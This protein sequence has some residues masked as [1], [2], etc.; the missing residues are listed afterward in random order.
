MHRER[1]ANLLA[2]HASPGSDDGEGIHPGRS[3]SELAQLTVGCDAD[4]ICVGHTHEPLVCR[5]E[6]V[7]VVNLGS[8]SNPTAPDLRASYVMIDA[9]AS[10]T[11]IEHRRVDYDHAA[12]IEAVRSSRHPEAEFILN[13]QRGK[14]VGRV[15][16]ADQSY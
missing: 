16:H 10:G 1:F 14:K 9:S 12:F 8:V 6:D 13:F 2:V 3:L 5:V 11:T 4:I 7:R 15:P